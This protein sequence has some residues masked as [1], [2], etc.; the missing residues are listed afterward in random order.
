[1]VIDFHVHGK[2][3]S[4]FE[5]DKDKFLLKINEAKKNGLDSIALTEHCHAVNF[6]EGYEFLNSHYNLVHDYFELDGFKVFYGVEVTTKQKLDILFIGNP[7]AVINFR[8][9][10]SRNYD[11]EKFIDINDLFKIENI[12]ELFIIIAHPYRKHIVFPDLEKNVL[13]K[14]NALEFNS[15]D[16]YKNGFNETIERVTKLA[17][18]YNLP[19]V[20]GSDTHYYKQISTAKNILNKECKNIKEIKDEI[21]SNNHKVKISED[22][23]IRVEEAIKIKKAMCNK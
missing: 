9:E 19:I 13:N 4:K 10:I 12:N 8:E 17:N 2:I 1:M 7:K 23:L 6:F 14:I 20:C 3:S 22:L 21:K 18:K 5:F 15:K 11:D 16:L